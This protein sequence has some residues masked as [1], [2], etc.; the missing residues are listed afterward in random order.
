MLFRFFTVLA[1]AAL[2]ISTWFLT[3]PSRALKPS[4]AENSADLP[5]YYLKNA[6][7]TDYDEKGDAGL[8]IEAERIDQVPR[9]EEVAMYNVKLN[10]QP[11]EGQAWELVGDTAHVQPGTKVIKVD[12]NVKLQGDAIAVGRA[13]E[14][15]I[16]RTDTLSYDLPAGIVT[17]ASDVR[18]QFGQHTLLSRG[19]SANLKE[20]TLRLESK[21]NGHF[22]P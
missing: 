18:V 15:P 3:S 7:L 11:P 17:S 12:G 19:L 2:A 6:V 10:Y 14:S 21:V 22:H 8:R 1:V 5:G 13:S 16:I 20:Q 4:A 9:S